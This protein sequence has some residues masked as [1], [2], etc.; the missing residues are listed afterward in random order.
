MKAQRPGHAV[1]LAKR[2]DAALGLLHQLVALRGMVDPL[3]GDGAGLDG[4]A[5]RAQAR[6]EQALQ[7]VGFEFGAFGPAQRAA[8]VHA[9][10]QL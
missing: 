5:T 3:A 1:A 9:L 4:A 2:I 7:V 6:P 8:A 10:H